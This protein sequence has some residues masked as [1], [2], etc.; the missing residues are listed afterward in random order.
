MKIKKLA[1]GAFALALVS[2]VNAAC[3]AGTNTLGMVDQKEACGLKGR[4]TS[5]VLLTAEGLTQ[6]TEFLC[7]QEEIE[8]NAKIGRYSLLDL[9]KRLT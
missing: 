9:L 1:L 8:L 3:P 2:Q 7:V 5:D 4:Y 6:I